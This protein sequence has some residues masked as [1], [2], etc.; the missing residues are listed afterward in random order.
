MYIL[1][2]ANLLCERSDLWNEIVGNLEEHL[3]NSIGTRLRLRCSRHNAPTDVQ[4]PV[5]F[6]PIPEG[7]CTRMC[8]ETLEC[9]H[10]VIAK[11][12]IWRYYNFMNN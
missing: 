7:G 12:I 10:Q 4:W 8:G 1:G 3:K 2:N 6:A 11:K 9:G 5:D